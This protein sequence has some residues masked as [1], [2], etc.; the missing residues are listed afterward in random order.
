MKNGWYAVQVETGREEVASDYVALRTG[1][2]CYY[3]KALR[4]IKPRW[5]KSKTP[6]QIKTAAFKGWIFV[7]HQENFDWEQLRRCP[8]IFIGY[9]GRDLRTFLIPDKAIVEIRQREAKGDFASI[10]CSDEA[11]KKLLLGTVV[12]LPPGPFENISEAVVVD[13]TKT[14]V[15]LQIFLLGTPTEIIYPIF[16]ICPHILDDPS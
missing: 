2:V 6:I 16:D 9:C 8:A 13:A 15:T 3:P 11:I 14:S 5:R 10:T 1:Y 7:Q 12:R 4:L